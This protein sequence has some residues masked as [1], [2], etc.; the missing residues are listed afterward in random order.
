MCLFGLEVAVS[1]LTVSDFKTLYEVDAMSI[2][3]RFFRCFSKKISIEDDFN[4]QHI[5]I[6]VKQ[7]NEYTIE[8]FTEYNSI[9]K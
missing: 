7:T 3:Q 8:D 6:G 1:V 2:L 5:V 4:I 9:Q